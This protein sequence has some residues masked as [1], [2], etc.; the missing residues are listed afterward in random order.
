MHHILKTDPLYWDAIAEGRKS[1]E[2]R[3]DDRGFDVGDT[4]EL[5]RIDRLDISSS[6]DGLDRLYSKIIFILRGGQYGI[7]DG[8]CV[9]QLGKIVRNKGEIV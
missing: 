6:Y 3:F 2:V 7:A 8:Y 1:F 5:M 4:L 9:L